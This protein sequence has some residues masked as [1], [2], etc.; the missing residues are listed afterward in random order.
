[1]EDRDFTLLSRNA[2]HV[3]WRRLCETG[4]LGRLCSHLLPGRALSPALE[5]V[6]DHEERAGLICA[7]TAL[8]A[9]RGSYVAV[10]DPVC[11]DSILP[12]EGFWG[13]G[14]A[15]VP[16]LRTVLDE[17][18]ARVRTVNP[19]RPGFDLARTHSWSGGALHRAM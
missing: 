9:V 5:Q 12:P 6:T 18:A 10:G 7:L 3:F 17:A 8:S 2:S 13:M 11:G 19:R 16:W 15:G 4:A 14:Q 1:M